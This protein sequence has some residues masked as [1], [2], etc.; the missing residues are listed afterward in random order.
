MFSNAYQQEAVASL[1]KTF[2]QI[3]E[4]FADAKLK[5]RMDSSIAF[6]Q[7]LAEE[8]DSSNH[9]SSYINLVGRIHGI[10]LNDKVV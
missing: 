1:E 5:G 4:T 3:I 9:P 7:F 10:K 2:L 6:A 8:V